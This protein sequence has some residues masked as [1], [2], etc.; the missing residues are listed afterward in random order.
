MVI[1]I[2]TA[3]W[4]FFGLSENVFQVSIIYWALHAQCN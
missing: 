1:S 4:V 3:L 2:E